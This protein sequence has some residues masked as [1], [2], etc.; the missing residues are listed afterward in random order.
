MVLNDSV[1][2]RPMIIGG[3]ILKVNTINLTKVVKCKIHLR[4]RTNHCLTRNWDECIIDVININTIVSLID[5]N[6]VAV[7]NPNGSSLT[8]KATTSLLEV[9]LEIMVSREDEHTTSLS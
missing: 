5:F 8:N 6:N 2:A 9:S 7:I 1:G 3:A 4:I